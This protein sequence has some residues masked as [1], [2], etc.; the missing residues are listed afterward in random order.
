MDQR[1]FE[2]KFQDGSRLWCTQNKEFRI[3]CGTLDGGIS[4]IIRKKFEAIPEKHIC[5]LAYR[6]SKECDFGYT[7]NVEEECL[8]LHRQ[9]M[10]AC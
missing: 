5:A 8:R 3:T 9:L 7:D 10:K 2:L 4:E 1:L 6:L